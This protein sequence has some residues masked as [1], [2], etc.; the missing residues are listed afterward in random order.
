MHRFQDSRTESIPRYLFNTAN[1]GHV[2][3]TNGASFG[4]GAAL[5]AGYD[6][7]IATLA[8]NALLIR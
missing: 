5:L 7:E 8:Q 6:N 3:D 2:R 1:G 4:S